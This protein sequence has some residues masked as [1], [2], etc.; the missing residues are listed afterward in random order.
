VALPGHD[1]QFVKFFQQ[2][3]R[4]ATLLCQSCPLRTT[5]PPLHRIF[6]QTPKN[7]ID[8]RPEINT[9]QIISSGRFKPALNCLACKFRI[10]WAELNVFQIVAVYRR[11]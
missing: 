2:F 8:A 5:N 4:P 9:M 10:R 11:T 7:V 1:K 3:L 6:V